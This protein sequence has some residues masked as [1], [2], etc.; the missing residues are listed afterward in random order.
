MARRLLI[1]VS[2]LLVP[3]CNPGPSLDLVTYKAAL[4]EVNGRARART[5]QITSDGPVLGVER[6]VKGLW[7]RTGRIG[8]EAWNAL[9]FALI[10]LRGVRER[11]ATRNPDAALFQVWARLGAREIDFRRDPEEPLEKDVVSVRARLDGIWEGLTEPEDVVGALIPFLDSVI[12]HVRGLAQSALA[13]VMKSPDFPE[14]DRERARTALEDMLLREESPAL[15]DTLVR[16]L[17]KGN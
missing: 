17:K 4:V 12:P 16:D 6:S 13:S 9:R 11:E 10:D 1:F 5:L 8:E 14:E 15:V 2:L 7:V 3:A